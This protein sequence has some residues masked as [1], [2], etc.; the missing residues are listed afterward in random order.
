MS[1]RLDPSTDRRDTVGADI[2]ILGTSS[3]GRTVSAELDR[4]GI[5]EYLVLD[6]QDATAERTDGTHRSRVTALDF[7]A[8]ADRWQ[9][10]MTDGRRYRPR[11]VIAAVGPHLADIPVTGPDGPV[12][13]DMWRDGPASFLGVVVHGL[14]NL[15]LTGLDCGGAGIAVQARY[16]RQCVLLMRRTASTRIEVRAATQHEFLR[17]MNSA[18]L[19]ASRNSAARRIVSVHRALR[20]PHRRHFDLTVAA[21]REPAHEYSGPA[22]LDAPGAEVAVTVTLNGHPDPIDGRYHWYGRVSGPDP[23]ALPDPG[24]GLVQLTL[25][26]RAPAAA[27]LQ[28]RDTWGNLRIVGVGDPPYPLASVESY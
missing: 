9:V 23:A 22:T 17:R 19:A 28:E 3:G 4:A 21:D 12:L 8:E 15:F 27:T 24:R 7:D 5:D 6:M 25:P 14:P 20:R 11:L 16:I 13:H 10:H 2:V 1:D 26:G 18:P